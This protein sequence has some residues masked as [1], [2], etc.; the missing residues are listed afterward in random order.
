MG[1]LEP[2]SQITAQI[3]LTHFFSL[4]SSLNIVNRGNRDYE[5]DKKNEYNFSI[6]KNS[7]K[8]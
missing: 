3:I 7:I 5:Q 8:T 1:Y 6:N 4:V 2:K